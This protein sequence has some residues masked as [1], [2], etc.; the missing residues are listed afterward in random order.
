[1]L[2]RKSPPKDKPAAT[3]V[4][5]DDKV[6]DSSV[7]EGNLVA[8]KKPKFISLVGHP[9]NQTGLKVIRNDQDTKGITNMSTLLRRTRRSDVKSPVMRLAFPEGTDEAGV[10]A[11]LQEF[12]M[13]D[14]KVEKEGNYYVAIRSDLKSISKETTMEIKLSDDGL[15]ATVARQD[16]AS[17][18]ENEANSI[19]MA[20]VSFDA[21]KFTLEEVKR[22]VS[23][24][25]VDGTIQE[26]QNP[27]ESY[28]VRRSDVKENEETRQLVLEDGV[29][30]TIVRSCDCNVPDGMVAVV[31]ETAYGSWGWGQMDFAAKMADKA[32]CNQ[33][34]DAIYSLRSVLDQIIIYS[35][36]PLDT[37]KDLAIRALG[38][39][40]EYV[41]AVLDS[42]PRQL[43][44]SVVRSAN[45]TSEK[46]MT[47]QTNGG[48]SN[49]ATATNPN[50]ADTPAANLTR[51]DVAGLIK[52]GLAEFAKTLAPSA[53]VRSEEPAK[54]ET[55]PAA[56]SL[57]R[58]D[59]QKMISDGSA[60]IL[61]EIKKL[62]GSTLVRSAPEGTQT[63]TATNQRRDVFDGAFGLPRHTA[64][65]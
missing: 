11:R 49:P 9:A 30:A 21:N 47:Q 12:G 20:A 59:V 44:V 18:G 15:I 2:G 4:Q 36:L 51:E 26:P 64:K 54:T 45:P 38:Q 35:A 43:L 10:A 41:G 61:E 32:F 13:T 28:V 63:Q 33:M 56:E 1:M 46:P 42:L 29:T 16:T 6:I 40:G 19:T 55:P 3:N 65:K 58:A 57:T 27:G 17:K 53:L 39:F 25:C 7:A 62:Q 8:V 34:D 50:A 31:S 52:E 24:K 14:Y 23:E 60:S 48:A 22:W 37:R 5:R